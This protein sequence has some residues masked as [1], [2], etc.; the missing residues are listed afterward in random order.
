[1][2][3]IDATIMTVADSTA[4]LRVFTKQRGGQNG[5]ASYPTLRL[6]AVVACGTR[7]LQNFDNESEASYAHYD[8]APTI[9]AE[10]VRYGQQVIASQLRREK[11]PPLPRKMREYEL[12][13]EDEARDRAGQDEADP[14]YTRDR[15]KWLEAHRSELGDEPRGLASH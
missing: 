5:A 14:D 8:P 10:A 9:T 1:V 15:D 2:C 13:L 7:T 12:A 6:L 11:L 4:N 3:A